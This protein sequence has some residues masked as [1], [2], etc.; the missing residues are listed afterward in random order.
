[1]SITLEIP[2]AIWLSANQ[3]IH[4]SEKARRTR[5]VRV[6][7]K[8]AAIRS[9]KHQRAVI[10]AWVGYPRAGR[11]DPANASPLVK[12]AIDGLVDAGVLP[13][14]NSDHLPAVTFRRDVKCRAGIHTLRLEISPITQ[15][16]IA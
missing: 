3:R 9:P 12:A 6:M 7:A 8:S 1:M 16:G 13:D 10:T 14:D 2:D 15:E 4:W 11:V 5:W